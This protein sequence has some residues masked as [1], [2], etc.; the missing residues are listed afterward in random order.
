[1]QALATVLRFQHTVTHGQPGR[2]QQA[3]SLKGR[4]LCC[5]TLVPDLDMQIGHFTASPWQTSSVSGF[6]SSPVV[7]LGHFPTV[8]SNKSL[9]EANERQHET[10][11]C[12]AD[13]GN[14]ELDRDD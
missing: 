5:H 8:P 1:M 3:R 12:P 7:L 11:R 6:P 14:T 9:G 4:G 10:V 2:C 13:K